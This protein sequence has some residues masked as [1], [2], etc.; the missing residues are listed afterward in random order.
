MRFVNLGCGS[1]FHKDWINYDF[2][3]NN[4]QIIATDLSSGIPEANNSVDVTYSSHV[5]EHFT[6]TQGVQFI[7]ECYRILKPGGTIRIVV[8]D[9]EVIAKNYTNKLQKAIS[10]PSE[11]AKEEYNWAILELLDQLVREISGGEMLEYW[12]KDHLINE[13][14]IVS[15][16]GHEFSSLRNNLLIKS[17]QN[18]NSSSNSEYSIKN[19]VKRFLLKKFHTSEKNVLAGNFRNDGEVHKW[20][21]DRF[22]LSELLIQSGFSNVKIKNAFESSIPGWEKFSWL[23]VE[24]GES[25][26]PDSL[27]I[28]A[29]K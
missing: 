13:E 20:M 19:R 2:V 22:S 5:L 6:K 10:H 16:V 29:I 9:L 3:S 27:F 18:L 17:K 24:E 23:D 28:E 11:L 14:Q 15:R 26:K 7:Q 1:R 25:R 12:K 4:P 8:P 21:Y